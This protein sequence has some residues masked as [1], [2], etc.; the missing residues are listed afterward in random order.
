MQDYEN[1]AV[2]S[3]TSDEFLNEELVSRISEPT[4]L[5]V[6]PPSNSLDS[7]PNLLEIINDEADADDEDDNP[8]LDEEPHLPSFIDVDL[9]DV[10]DLQYNPPEPPMEGC[11][12]IYF[13]PDWQWKV[14]ATVIHTAPKIK[15]RWPGW[16]NV[17]VD[18]LPPHIKMKDKSKERCFNYRRVRWRYI[19]ETPE[20]DGGYLTP[21]RE[22]QPR[23]ETSRRSLPTPDN[24]R[25]SV[26]APERFQEV[27]TSQRSYLHHV[28]PHPSQVGEFNQLLPLRRP[29][30]PRISGLRQLL[31]DE[32]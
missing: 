21:V 12:V 5:H 26:P 20:P 3:S 18:I 23:D 30:R 9:G 28:L 13:D 24:S 1:I 22:D 17:L 2:N 19:T 7:R 15:T 14:K 32:K 10:S 25:R 27:D 8:V 11:R 4:G 6:E 16:Y 31:P 29:R